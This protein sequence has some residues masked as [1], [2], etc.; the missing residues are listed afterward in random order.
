MSDSL[1]KPDLETPKPPPQQ[2]VVEKEAKSP[3]TPPSAP[4]H[5]YSLTF[6]LEEQSTGD[7]DTE[8][9]HEN[10]EFEESEA[11]ATG[12]IIPFSGYGDEWSSFLYVKVDG[13]DLPHKGGAE[14]KAPAS[15]ENPQGEDQEDEKDQKTGWVPV[16]EFFFKFISQ[17]DVWEN[18]PEEQK[19]GYVFN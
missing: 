7:D 14:P 2:G 6:Y 16:P 1:E 5:L 3:V 13:K 4:K 19:G 15:H 9:A 10:R 18:V 12:A 17:A 11:F 8:T